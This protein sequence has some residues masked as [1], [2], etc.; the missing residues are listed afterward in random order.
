MRLRNLLLLVLC[1]V[2]VQA[3]GD[4]EGPARP[5]VSVGEGTDGGRDSGIIRPIFPTGDGGDDDDGG[6]DVD[7][8]SDA[9]D[10]GSPAAPT[11]CHN[12][13][14]VPPATDPDPSMN[15]NMV[16]APSDLTV[17]RAAATWDVNCM[18]PTLRV[19][20]SSGSCPNGD[21]HEVTFFVP[22]EGVEDSTVVL[23]QNVIMTDSPGRIR[24][25]YT[26]PGRVNPDGEWGSCDGVVGTLDLIR[27]LDLIEGR[28][29]EG[30][31][32]ID[33]T[34]CDDGAPSIQVLE[35]SFNV[36]IPAS[37]EDICP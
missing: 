8:N 24:V 32:Q 3:C 19:S 11:R 1:G 36:E 17:T 26:R 16:T 10:S 21:G 5:G 20:L 6:E 18:D 2:S 37:L 12:V 27:Q 23:G 30:D 13:E 15:F 28:R 29:L 25:R 14:P 4:D 35:G 31:F 7:P 9:G 22:A 34:R 33:L